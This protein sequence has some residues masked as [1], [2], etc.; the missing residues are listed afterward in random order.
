M[1]EP[2]EDELKSLLRTW[3][4]PEAPESLEARV[5]NAYRLR[6]AALWKWLLTGSVRVPVPVAAA[7]LAALALSLAW[8][9]PSIPPLSI[10]Y[11]MRTIEVPVV[12]E[13]VV[14]RER[15]KPDARLVAG[16][17]TAGFQPVAEFKPR[18][19]RSSDAA[20]E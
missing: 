13:R 3:Q 8:R 20:R 4:A 15:P 16:L 11:R 18:I 7:A 19:I 17:G 2:C 6:R 1:K 5:L 9:A 12:R 10:T 14:Y